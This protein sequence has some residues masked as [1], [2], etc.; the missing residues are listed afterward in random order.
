MTGQTMARGASAQSVLLNRVFLAFIMV[1][2]GVKGDCGSKISFKTIMAT[3]PKGPRDG[4]KNDDENNDT[5][6]GKDAS[7]Q[8]R[9][10]QE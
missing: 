6:K 3:F 10:L 5:D 1:R 2:H 9:I 7:L 8:G 4:D